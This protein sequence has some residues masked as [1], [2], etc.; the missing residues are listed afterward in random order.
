MKITSIE[1]VRTTKPIPLP[2]EYREAWFQPDGG[3][4]TAYGV[5]YLKISTDEGII[6]I[7]PGST[8]DGYVRR[9]LIGSDPFKTEEFWHAAMRGLDV[10][11]RG[12][13][14]GID[15]A[16]WDL[17]GKA[18]GLPTYKLLGSKADKIKVYAATSRLCAPEEHVEQVKYIMSQGFKAVKLRFHRPDYKDEL[19]VVE[20]VRK[21]CGDE[22]MLMVDGNQNHRSKNYQ[23]WSRET[24]RYLCAGLQELG[25]YFFEEPLNRFDYDGLAKLSAE[26]DMYI[27]GG[28]HCQHIYEFKEHFKQ[29]TYDVI[30]PDVILGDVGIT[31]IIKLGH[32]AEFYD[33]LIIPHVCGLGGMSFNFAGCAAAAVGLNNCP[34][35]EFPFD[36]PFLTTETQ[37]FFLKN[38]FVVDADGYVLMPQTP[39]IGIE[40]DYD[41]LREWGLDDRQLF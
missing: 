39:G 22:I 8:V 41:A 25:V 18:A 36:P 34:I 6:G 13:Y 1:N 35:I 2:G 5:E 16:L 27:A 30:Q 23:H 7:G 32:A 17:I 15:V 21:A 3:G 28:E 9:L 37:M 14:G 10:Y 19:K 24:A 33:K 20:A 31:G 40:L 12:F 38:K 29:N 26:F 4:K 11:A